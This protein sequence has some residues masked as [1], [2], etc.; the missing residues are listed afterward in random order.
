MALFL[1]SCAPAPEPAAP[2]GTEPQRI[3]SLDYCA[4][5]YVLRFADR[6]AILALSPYAGERFSYMRAEAE[7]LPMVRP[8]TADILALRPDL[9]IRS[10]GGGADV[11]PFLEDLGV[12][13]VQIGFPQTIAEVREE[14]VRVGSALGAGAEAQRVAAD[15]DRRLAALPAPPDRPRTALYMTPGGM[16]SGEGTLVHEILRTAGLANFQDRAGWNILPLERLAY[17]RPDVVAPAFYEGV[18]SQGDIWSAARH[19]VAQAQLENR[20]VVPLEGAWT[21]CG[22]WF[23]ID[24]IEALSHAAQRDAP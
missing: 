23:L 24:A 18:E 10:F 19:P 13:V 22:G 5:Q 7:G 9:V 1:A 16:T 12:P 4:D 11:V 14:V 20:P 21:S 3:V 6:D 8:R 17:E 2:P 15:M